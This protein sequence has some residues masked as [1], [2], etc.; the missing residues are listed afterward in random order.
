MVAVLFMVGRHLESPQI[1]E[2]LLDTTKVPAKPIYEMASE[3]PLVLYDCGFEDL[4]WNKKEGGEGTSDE[5]Q[6]KLVAH[7]ET[8]SHELY[9][10]SRV[11]TLMLD[12]TRANCPSLPKEYL[13]QSYANNL[14]D[15]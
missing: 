14:N 8:I 10:K 5:V 6:R 11:A 12:A 7:F 9:L 1:V 4:H 2:T 3:I 15:Y 13:P